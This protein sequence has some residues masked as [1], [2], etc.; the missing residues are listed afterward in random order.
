MTEDEMKLNC[1]Q[2]IALN[3]RSAFPKDVP[4]GVGIPSHPCDSLVVPNRHKSNPNDSNKE[5][6][7]KAVLPDVVEM[8][9]IDYCNILNRVLP[10]DI[11]VLGWT[12]VDEGFSS[13][14]SAAGRSYRYFFVRKALDI[15]SMRKAL[16]Y[17]IGE[18]DF[19]NLCKL[20]VSNVSNFRREIFFARIV[21][22]RGSKDI[23][24]ADGDVEMK[25]ADS[26]DASNGDGDYG[27][28]W[29]LEITGIAFLW[30]MIRCI[31]AVLFLV[32]EGKEKPE[33]VQWLLNTEQCPAKPFY[34][35]AED[36]PLVLNRCQF[37]NLRIN[38]QPSVLWSLHGH[39]E[40]IWERHLLAAARAENALQFLNGCKV[41]AVDW[42]EFKEILLAKYF[43]DSSGVESK[44]TTKRLLAADSGSSQPVCKRL[45]SESSSSAASAVEEADVLWIMAL[46]EVM[47]EYRL[48]PTVGVTKY[49]PLMQ[50]RR[51]STYSDAWSLRFADFV[52]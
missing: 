7:K 50:V 35:M 44:A 18:H 27:S 48:Y 49:Q 3:V 38:M 52:L 21:P 13:R 39:F 37:D 12:E 47:Q 30:H 33:I 43:E 32:G 11:R 29:M 36:L 2:V 4:A 6:S 28:V 5:V 10:E 17:L 46:E 16:Q 51:H 42:K 22:F 14:F 40:T 19:R 34:H 26:M 24:S 41:R 23:A 9:E 31:M 20:D 8:K 45:K 25:P 1:I 15:E